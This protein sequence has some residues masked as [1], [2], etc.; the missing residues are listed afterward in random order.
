M[1]R[2]VQPVELASIYVWLAAP[3]ASYATGQI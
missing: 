1:E 3:N 2:S